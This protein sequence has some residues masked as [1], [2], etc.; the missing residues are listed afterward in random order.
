MDMLDKDTAGK[1]VQQPPQAQATSSTLETTLGTSGVLILPVRRMVLFPGLTIPIAVGR[2][3]S[4]SAVELAEGASLPIGVFMQKEADRSDPDIE[5]LSTVGTLARVMHHVAAPDG[6]HHII[7]RGETRIK[8]GKPIFRLPCLAA[9]FTPIEKSITRNAQIDAR[10]LQLRQRALE[11]VSLLPSAPGDLAQTVASIDDP[12]LLADIVAQHL[13]LE[14]QEKQAVL[15]TYDLQ[16][17][18]DRMLEL[19]IYRIEVL[20]IS[21]DIGKQTEQSL[22]AQQR[23]HILREQ[24][25]AIRK[26]LGEVN[27]ESEELAALK[28]QIETCGM[29]HEAETDV[30]KQHARL[31]RMSESSTEYSMMRSYLETLV[32]LP[33]TAPEPKMIDLE[34]AKTILDQDHYDLKKI[35]TR[36]LEHLAVRKLNP[37]GRSPILCF[38]GPPGVGKTSLGQSIAKAMN[39]KFVRLSLGGIDDE[40]EIRGHRMTYIG[41]MPG[42]IIKSLQRVGTQDCV[43]MLDEID[44]LG[45]S[46]HGDPAAALLEVL[47]PVQNSAFRDSYLDLPF[48]L[49]KVVFI[50]TANVVE[51][52]PGPLRDRMEVILLSGYTHEE[53]REIALRYLIKQQ[54]AENGLKASQCTI[55]PAAID[56]IIESYTWEAGVRNLEREIGAVMR[57]AAMRIAAGEAKSVTL[58]PKQ[59]AAALGPPKFE[60][61]IAMLK[62]APGIA[63]GL[64]WTSGGGEIL[65][66]EAILYPGSGKLTLT[67]QL[68]HVMRESAEA[69]LSL[70]KSLAADIGIDT[71]QFTKCDI[72]IHVPA[73]AIPKDGPSAGTAIFLALASALK[74]ECVRSDTAITGEISLRGL[75]LPVGGIKDKVI[76]ADRAGVTRVLL[77]KRNKRDLEEIPESVLDHVE[78]IWIDTVLEAQRMSFGPC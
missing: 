28:A 30:L 78:I 49:S 57:T 5:D 54:L 22:S 70:V 16:A 27:G 7:V 63:T 13:D 67:G 68:G 11:A 73:G 17:K 20:R 69:A 64:A 26:E 29:N 56:L 44:K 14:S 59:V 19:L 33:W 6:T 53:K 62:G 41:A 24:L 66:I 35:K 55:K 38:T 58:G 51:A 18:L 71:E 25:I 60:R 72:H 37:D 23:Q 77:P 36:I 4:I 31:E 32:D 45:R 21:R 34:E 46:G 50:T 65:F 1:S 2:T 74:H 9:E 52:I 10:F 15:E 76:A 61:D 39:R 43:F 48:D 3:K 12:S 42:N 40:S 75:I 47:D 8:I